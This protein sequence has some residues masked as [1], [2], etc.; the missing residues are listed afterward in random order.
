MTCCAGDFVSCL[1][2]PGRNA[3]RKEHKN[4]HKFL[5]MFACFGGGFGVCSIAAVPNVFLCE[6]MTCEVF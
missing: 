3:N 2:Q 1:A 5:F 6:D 4:K